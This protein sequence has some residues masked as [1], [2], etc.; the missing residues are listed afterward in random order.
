M[1]LWDPAFEWRMCESDG[2]IDEPWHW[3]VM[4]ARTFA[5]L[6]VQYINADHVN[7]AKKGLSRHPTP[8]RPD[9]RV[10][11]TW[12]NLVLYTPFHPAC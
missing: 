1:L 4:R 11:A 8:S 9:F 10:L 6:A 12:Y 3:H 5:I 2:I 7:H